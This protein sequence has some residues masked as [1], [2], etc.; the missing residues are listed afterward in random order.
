M[1]LKISA[2]LTSLNEAQSRF[3]LSRTTDLQF[4]SEWQ[5]TLPELS[6]GE[7]ETLDRVKNSYLYNS[8]DGAMTE[9]T[10]NLLLVSPLLYLAGFCDPPYKLRGL[11]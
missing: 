8:A 4:F 1:S 5:E 7:R 9:A 6:Q 11:G 3:N 2:H 10:V